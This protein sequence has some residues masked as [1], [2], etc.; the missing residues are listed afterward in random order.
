LARAEHLAN[1]VVFDD[2]AV[3]SRFVDRAEL[4]Q[5]PLRKP[6]AVDGPVRIV[7]VTAFDWSACGGTHVSRTGQV[8]PIKILRAERRKNLSR[9]H[10]VCGKRATADYAHKHDIVQALSAHLTTSGDELLPSVERLEADLKQARKAL[11]TVQMELLEY[12]VREWLAEAV[13]CGDSR[14]VQVALQDADP[15]VLREAA[16][17]VIEHSG[18]V[19]LLAAAEPRPQF[20]FAAAADVDADMG[21]LMRA[22]TAAAGGRGG[23]RPQF[24]QGG[25]PVG[26]PVQVVLDA[27]CK[28]LSVVVQRGTT[29]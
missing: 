15:A 25:A 17:R 22:A 10:F 6:P 18:T 8:G 28:K 4:I 27:A 24:A 1:S 5:M 23:G 2:R 3:T 26:V 21:A 19:A 12:R 20:V 13:P 14:V 11:S 29:E 16:R 7:H 9:V